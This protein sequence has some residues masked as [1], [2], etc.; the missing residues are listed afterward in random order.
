M[1]Y[2]ASA[3]S[4]MKT[5]TPTDETPPRSSGR[6]YYGIGYALTILTLGSN[7]PTALYGLYR[8]DLGFSPLTQTAIFATVGVARKTSGKRSQPGWNV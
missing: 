3:I 6:H 8:A 1:S 5:V 4:P 7:I 2:V